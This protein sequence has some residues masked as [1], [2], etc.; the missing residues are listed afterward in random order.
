[1]NERL[2]RLNREFME[3]K[4]RIYHEKLAH[5]NTQISQLQDSEDESFIV[6]VAELEMERE[7]VI[8][9][10]EAYRDYMVECAHAVY[11]QETKQCMEEYQAEKQS[12]QDKILSSLQEKRRKLLEERDTFDLI[13]DFANANGGSS[14]N[15]GNSNDKFAGARKTRMMP[16][17]NAAREAEE[18]ASN[19][20]AYDRGLGSKR[21]KKR[22][23]RV[24]QLSYTLKENEL[25]EDMSFIRK[26][27]APYKKMGKSKR[28][29]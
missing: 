27:N 12:L 23:E 8:Y 11:E 26:G 28:N 6:R 14:S 25:A 24:P 19:A 7:D 29:Q 13:A 9:H 22:R 18:A 15:N 4:D 2:D 20:A 16:S 1:M 5:I 3:T 17:R 21:E 10:A